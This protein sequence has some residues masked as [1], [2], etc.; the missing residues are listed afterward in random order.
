MYNI[1][2]KD[3]SWLVSTLEKNTNALA[4]FT[5]TAGSWQSSNVMPITGSV[6]RNTLA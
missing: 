1:R 4:N 3:E 6:C 5:G 2:G